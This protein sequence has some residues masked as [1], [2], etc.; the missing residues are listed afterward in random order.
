MSGIG[1]LYYDRDCSWCRRAAAFLR[2][3]RQAHLL[4]LIPADFRELSQLPAPVDAVQYV[5]GGQVWLRSEA[6][7]RALYDAGWRWIAK[8]LGAIPLAWRDRAYDWVAAHRP[9]SQKACLP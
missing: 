4:Q 6:I 1:K 7:R 8:L 5:R 2:Q 3:G 9:C